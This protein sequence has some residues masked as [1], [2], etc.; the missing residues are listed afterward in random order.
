LNDFV[1]VYF[2]DIIVYSNNPEE[3]WRH[4][5]Q[6]LEKLQE[7]KVNLKITKCEFG[8]KETEFLGQIING[9]T[10][11][12]QEEKVKA[13]LDWPTPKEKDDIA[14]FRGLTG[15]YRQYIK[16]FSDKMRPLNEALAKKEFEWK[17]KEEKAFQQIKDEY[18]N[19]KILLLIDLEKQIWVHADA[20]D[21]AL[22]RI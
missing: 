16:K 22:C 21:Y 3:H 11:R 13:I 10:M 20:S 9:G 1:V 4:V 6:V 2:D 14:T 19:E 8:V 17:E 5:E 7:S 18:R 15:Y 12:M